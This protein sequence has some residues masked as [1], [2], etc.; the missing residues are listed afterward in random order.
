MTQPA[1]APETCDG[2]GKD[3]RGINWNSEIMV[4]VCGGQYRLRDGRWNALCE[5]GWAWA[6]SHRAPYAA[7]VAAVEQI[8]AHHVK[9]GRN[10]ER[11]HTLSIAR[12]A[13]DLARKADA[14]EH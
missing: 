10:E 14:N 7:L 5:D 3:Q 4:Y 9:A 13:L 11:S 8:E 1:A 6:A 2:C 12:A